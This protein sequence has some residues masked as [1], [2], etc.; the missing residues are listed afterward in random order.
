MS[1]VFTTLLTISA[2]KIGSARN[3]NSQDGQRERV[4]TKER[5]QGGKGGWRMKKEEDEQGKRP[6]LPRR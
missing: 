6:L 5:G 2:L 1:R 3:L 4:Y